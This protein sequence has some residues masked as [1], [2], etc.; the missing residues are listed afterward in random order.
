MKERAENCPANFDKI[1]KMNT[2]HSVNDGNGMEDNTN[3]NVRMKEY[4]LLNNALKGILLLYSGLSDDE[5]CT[6]RLNFDSAELT[7]LDATVAELD[8]V[9]GHLGNILNRGNGVISAVLL[10]LEILSSILASMGYNFLALLFFIN[11]LG[12]AFYCYFVGY[13]LALLS[14]FVADEGCKD[15]DDTKVSNDPPGMAGQCNSRV[16]LRNGDSN[17]QANARGEDST[18]TYHSPCLSSFSR[19]SIFVSHSV[20]ILPSILK[21]GV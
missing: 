16:D 12:A 17:S 6:P 11:S 20:R 5:N 4:Y 21:Q 19:P 18:G 1:N 7:A 3:G 10:M 14:I 8:P 13:S 15:K 9:Q 2:A